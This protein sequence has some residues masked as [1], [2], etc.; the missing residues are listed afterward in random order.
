MVEVGVWSTYWGG[1]GA[2]VVDG[3][4]MWVFG[5]PVLFAFVLVGCSCR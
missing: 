1:E 3:H 2:G 4:F 5:I